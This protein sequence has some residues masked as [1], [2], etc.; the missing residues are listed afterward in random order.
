MDQDPFI[1]DML[2]EL[3]ADADLEPVP[4]PAP[5]SASAAAAAARRDEAERKREERKERK[6]AGIPDGRTVDAAVAAAL[7]ETFRKGRAAEQILQ[8]GNIRG[9][10]FDGARVLAY[11]K[12]NLVAKG[13]SNDAAAVALEGRLFPDARSPSR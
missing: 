1:Q 10:I 9:F 12:R 6:A 2:D 11:A 3:A 4:P 7:A 8:R 13:V 5:V